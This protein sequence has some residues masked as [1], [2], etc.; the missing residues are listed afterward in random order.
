M[1]DS[2]LTF[3]ALLL[4]VFAAPAPLSPQPRVPVPSPNNPYGVVSRVVGFTD[5]EGVHAHHELMRALVGEWGYAAK[6]GHVPSPHDEAEINLI[7]NRAHRIIPLFGGGYPTEK[8]R[9]PNGTPRRDPDGSFR[10]AAAVYGDWFREAKRRQLPIF[11]FEVMN[12]INGDGAWT[13]EIYARWL[14]DLCVAIHEAHPAVGVCSCGMAGSGADYYDRML[15]AVPQLKDVVDFWNLHPYCANHPPDYDKDDTAVKGHHWTRRVLE[16]HGVK[17][18]RFILSELG[19]ELGDGKDNR[20]P[21]IDEEN[22]A[23]YMVEAFQKVYAPDRQVVAACP[24]ELWDLDQNWDAW[25]WIKWDGTLTPQYKAVAALPKPKGSDWL[26]RGRAS[27]RG[28]VTDAATGR[29]VPRAYVWTF[30]GYY[31]A[32]T[33]EKGAYVI[34][35][36]PPGAYQVRGDRSAFARPPPRDVTAGAGGAASADFVMTRTGLLPGGFDAAGKP[37]VGAG[38]QTFDGRDH[39]EC[40]ALDGA[41]KRGGASSQRMA[42]TPELQPLIWAAAAPLSAVHG[43]IYTAEVWVKMRGVRRG[44]RRGPVLELQ[45][46]DNRAQS[47]AASRAAP[48]ADGDA[49]WQP[50][51]AAIA[52]PPGGRRVRVN[53]ALDAEAGEC[54]FDDLF[55]HETPWPLPSD[56]ASGWTKK[57]ESG[58]RGTIAGTVTDDDGEPVAGATVSTQPGCLAA[59]TGADGAFSLKGAPAGTYAVR[60]AWK[61]LD[62]VSAEVKL[63]GGPASCALVLRR[64]RRPAELQN[65]GFEGH[66]PDPGYIVGWKKWGTL[67]G[68]LEQGK[69]IFADTTAH[70]GVRFLH[71]GAGSNTKS[72]GVFQTVTVEPGRTYRFGG[73]HRTMQ[74]G[75]E[76]GQTATRFGIDPA[77]GEDPAAKGVVWSPFAWHEGSWQEAGVEAAAKGKYLT[78]FIEF[79][80]IQ[81]N[82][83]N[84]N[85]VDDVELRMAK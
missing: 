34:D 83:W 4:A 47:L 80:Q 18:P 20:Y 36:L 29:P 68:I 76:K 16:K 19:Y 45:I 10:T 44:D 56:L 73:W 11:T 67:D 49:D 51:T 64:A 70:G 22:R 30:P 63:A 48:S 25:D 74:V 33:D 65:P 58:G 14:Y 52:C 41:V 3:P 77:G 81:G 85:W 69:T 28:R 9:A 23:R 53:L 5:S 57:A 7:R 46:A 12:E 42:A 13:P 27:V 21:R 55:V 59:V 39:P 62:P 60:A 37:T 8:H 6:A 54:W 50:L 43:R 71:S 61:D 38:W 15:A 78:V 24:F 32:T 2:H 17:T 66:G 84:A 31:A 82:E 75:G 26:P 72:G 1:R 40:F 35:G 79:Q